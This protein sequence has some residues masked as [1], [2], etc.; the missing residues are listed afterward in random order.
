MW[1]NDMGRDFLG[2]TLPPD[3]LNLIEEGKNYGWPWCY[4]QQV[5]DSDFF[6]INIKPFSYCHDTRSS[7]F[8]YPAH[9]APLGLAFISSPLFNKSDQGNILS[10]FHGSWNSSVPVGYKIV[11]LKVEEGKVISSEDFISGWSSG[12][13]VL[14]RPVDMVFDENGVLYI[15]DDKANLIYIL[16]K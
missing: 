9:I 7:T 3:E 2:D 4:G 15:S 10:A 13:G 12:K 14:G 8:D 5:S 16:T 6:N 11:K 1:G